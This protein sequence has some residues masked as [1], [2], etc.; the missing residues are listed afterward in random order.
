MIAVAIK[1]SGTLRQGDLVDT[2]SWRN[3]ATMLRCRH[4]R[5][6]SASELALYDKGVKNIHPPTKPPTPGKRASAA[7]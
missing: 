1:T 4:I 2:A 3:E 7:A 6:A 5:P